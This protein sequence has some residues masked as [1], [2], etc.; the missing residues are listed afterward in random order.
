MKRLL[1]TVALVALAA[2]G[3]RPRAR[4]SCSGRRREPR[5]AGALAGGDPRHVRRRDPPRCGKRRGRERQRRV[6]PRRAP[7]VAGHSLILPLRHALA[8]GAYSARWS[9][10]AQDGHREQGVLAFAVGAGAAAPVSILGASSRLSWTD[11]ALR[12]L[13]LARSTDRCRNLRVLAPDTAPVRR[14]AR[15]AR[16]PAAV[17]QPAHRLRRCGR[18]RANDGRRDALRALRRARR[19]HRGRRRSRGRPRRRTRAAAPGGG[20]LCRRCSPRPRRSPGTHSTAARPGGWRSRSISCISGRPPS[21]A[22]AWWRSSPSSEEELEASPHVVPPHAVSRPSRSARSVV[23]A[24]SGIGRSLSE[25]DAVHQVWSTSYGRALIVKTALFLPLLGVGR[26][27]RLRLAGGSAR[28]RTARPARARRA[29]RDR[30]GRRGV[31]GFAARKRVVTNTG[32]EA[33][34]ASERAGAHSRAGG[35]P[36]VSALSRWR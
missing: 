3:S 27:N 5:G 31:D 29:R 32:G 26:L 23:L 17:L 2:P 35:S 10:V 21:G 18:T 30:R 19:D 12:A 15:P 28:S 6:D 33:G 1:L 36:A 25:L 7:T 4:R 11:A 16:P 24:L 14:R 13:Y 22:A 20:P 9:I 34:S 8:R